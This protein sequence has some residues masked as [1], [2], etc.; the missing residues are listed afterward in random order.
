LSLRLIRILIY[1]NKNIIKFK[2]CEEELPSGDQ[3]I[4]VT[5]AVMNIMVAVEYYSGW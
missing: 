4:L 2:L 1:R 5:V 3:K